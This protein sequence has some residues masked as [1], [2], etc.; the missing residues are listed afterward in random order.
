MDIRPD[1]DF[2]EYHRRWASVYEA[3]NYSGGLAGRVLLRTHRLIEI[4]FGPERHMEKVLEV[5]AGTGVHLPFVRH[6]FGTYVMTDGSSEVLDRARIPETLRGKVE[7]RTAR[8]TRLDF[9][10]DAFDR[11]IATHVLEHLPAPHEVLR[12]WLRVLKPGGVLS[13][14][15][16][17]DPGLAW[18]L[19]RYFGP[20]RK[21]LEAGIDYDYWMAREHV[22]PITNLVTF[23]R[24]Y[25][26]ER[27]ERWWPFAF[28]PLPDVNLIYSVNAMPS[29]SGGT[30]K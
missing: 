8:A 5:G 26:P 25:F 15:L 11:V 1:P 16:P 20:R 30:R 22:N 21:A 28:L 9:P 24:H 18:R 7:C 6:G 4:D 3:N 14:I 10:D 12:E 27:R 17:C 23:V 29:P 2:D 19:G 13:L